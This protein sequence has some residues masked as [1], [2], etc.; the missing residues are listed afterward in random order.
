MLSAAGSIASILGLIFT[1]WVVFKVRGIHTLYKRHLLIPP[2][3]DKLKRH[4]KDAAKALAKKRTGQLKQ[5][6][7][8]CD[9]LVERL[10]R[11]ADKT[12][13]RRAKNVRGSIAELLALSH[14]TVLSSSHNVLCEL[15]AVISSAVTY[16]D[17]DKWR[18]RT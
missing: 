12:L 15:E 9:A 2:I 5:I 10:P 11:Y 17:E 7:Y 4:I 18:T 13:T 8:K 3:I 1:G 14:G 6:L 16:M